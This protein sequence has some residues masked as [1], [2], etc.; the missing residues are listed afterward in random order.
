MLKYLIEKEFKQIIRNKFLP[1]MIIVFP[2]MVLLVLPF[3]ANFE[4]KN[5]NLSILD[6]SH[7]TYS[8]RLI[9][10]VISSGYFRITNVSN[11]YSEALK[12]I[13]LDESDIILE[14]PAGFEKEIINDKITKVMISANTVNGTKGGLGSAYLS[15]IIYD[16]SNE[17]RNKIAVTGKKPDLNFE[18]VTQYRHNPNLKYSNFMVP[19]LMV[20]MLGIICGFL[21]ALNIVNEKENGTIE[22]MNVTPVK[23]FQFILSKLIPYWVIGFI[24]LNNTFIIA[25]LV[26]DL[27]P[28]GSIFTIYTIAS[29]FVLSYSGFGLVIS[30]YAK[31][32][33]QAMFMMF[34]FQITFILISGLYT[35]VNSMP[36]WAQFISHFSPLKYLII[37]MRSV[38]LKG[39]NLSQL[40]TPFISLIGFAVFFNAWAI[41]SYSKKDN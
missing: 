11:N 30:N 29:V 21:P 41:I 6:N 35:P 12:S 9:N 8:L 34:F 5:I 37:S 13:E 22:Q 4:I 16:F 38:Y 23:K 3:A 18:I 20:M 1:K 32:I 28:A 26:Y 14:I 19:A 36:Q 39:S 24:V 17:I 33:Q 40:L 15:G 25:W 7:S 10:K 2:I 27:T 31:T